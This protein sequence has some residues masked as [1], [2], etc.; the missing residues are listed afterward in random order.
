MRRLKLAATIL[1]L[2]CAGARIVHA[3]TLEPLPFDRPNDNAALR[4]LYKK[5]Q[6]AF[7]AG[8]YV[9]ARGLFLQA[10]SLS[11]GAEVALGLGQSE[12]ELKRFRDCAE[13]LDFAIHKLG[14]TVSER[15]LARAKKALAEAKAQVAL[16]RVSTPKDG[17]QIT[18][19]GVA[20]GTAPLEQPIYLDPGTH[21]IAARVGNNG[22][23][24]SV[25]VQAGQESS[26][27]LPFDSQ[28]KLVD[29]PW[30]R[31][32]PR[33]STPDTANY[34][35]AG[36]SPRSVVPVI[37]GGAVFLAGVTAAVVFRIDSDSQFNDA[38]ALRAKLAQAG[39]QGSANSG[40]CAALLAANQNGDRARNWSTAAIFVAAG[41]ALGT[42]AYWFWPSSDA[43]SSAGSANRARL[44]AGFAPSGILLSGNF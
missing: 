38:D 42:A 4:A 9:Q 22:I 40:D 7:E 27:R 18:V 31:N 15:V 12:Y 28:S 23:A 39:C 17:A 2:C 19:D 16:L 30:S 20:V 34:S 36:E 6:A 11:P 37:I 14:P 3:E 8:N 1:V 24:R 35:A 21:E 10:W 32:A 43:K 29:S 26:I 13:H 33:A 41:A 25:A 5:A 44:R